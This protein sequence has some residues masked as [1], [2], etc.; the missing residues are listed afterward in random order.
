VAELLCV[1]ADEAWWQEVRKKH[2]W[3]SRRTDSKH[4][5]KNGFWYPASCGQFPMENSSRLGQ[6]NHPNEGRHKEALEEGCTLFTEPPPSKF[7]KFGSAQCACLVHIVA[8]ERRGDHLGRRRFGHSWAFPAQFVVEV[9]RGQR[10]FIQVNFSIAILVNLVE[11]AI[12]H[13]AKSGR[14]GK[15][16]LRQVRHR[17]DHHSEAELDGDFNSS[18][19][20]VFDQ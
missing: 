11:S 3:R 16:E 5:L 8:L 20:T 15:I 2:G 13:L 17:P 4:N 19:R 12:T 6:D 9:A 18:T 14:L 7:M 10:Q 1:L